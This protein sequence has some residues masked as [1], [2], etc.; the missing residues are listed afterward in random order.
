MLT[1]AGN[2]KQRGKSD[3]S[4]R[5]VALEQPERYKI[6][7]R[8]YTMSTNMSG[9]GVATIVV[10]A[11]LASAV[12]AQAAGR[13][14][15][16]PGVVERNK[17][18]GRSTFLP[19]P[20][21]ESALKGTR[22]A[23]PFHQSLN[24]K[25]K[26]NWAAKP[27]KRPVEFYKPS[28][29]VSG[30][31]EIPVPANWQME[32][33]GIPIYCNHP[34]SFKKDPP[35]VMGT[36]PADWPAYNHRNPV[37]SY[38]RE[39]AIP[40]AWK[41]RRVFIHF[42]GV[43]SAFYL[44]VNGKK[45]GYS[46]GSRTP[47]EFDITPYMKS[48]KNVLAAEVY[49]YSD[50]TYLECQDFWR[51]S[52]IFRDVYLWS[53]AELHVRDFHADATLD[54]DYRNGVLSLNLDVH[55]FSAD[56]K[57]CSMK[58]E[59]LDAKGGSVASMSVGPLEAKP[60]AN[61]K[62]T[63]PR[64]TI[65]EPAQWSAEHPNLYKVLITLADGAGKTVEVVGCRVGFRKVEIKDGQ[66]LVNGRAIY[67]KGVNR[68]EHDPVTGHYITRESMIRDIK[69]MKQHNINAVRTCH[70]PDDPKWYD[71]CDEFGIYLIDEANIE[72][73][74]MG[75]GP[76]SLGKKPAWKK[77][78]LDRTIR[79]VERDK[80]H[81]SI[82][83]WSL[84]N[85]AG[86]GINFEATSAWIHK[87][88]PSR[89]VHYERAGKRPHTDIVC[90]MYAGIKSIEAYGSQPQ[91]RPLILCE[92]A[93]A[94][95]NSVGNLQDYWT[96]IEK[97]KHLQ[98]GFI[99]D[100]V[101]QGLL[102]TSSPS[103]AVTD[104]S[105]MGHAVKI[106]GTLEESSGAK[107]LRGHAVL[108]GAPSLNITGK[109]LTLEAWVKPEK[110][111]THSPIVGKG[112]TQYGLKVD[113]S[114]EKLEFNIYSKS[115]G[116]ITLN[117]PLPSDWLG[118]WRHV[119]GVY[120]GKA[121]KL[122]IDGKLV[123][124][125]KSSATI[126]S[127]GHPVNIGRNGQ[128]PSRTFRGLIRRVRIY[129]KA[130]P[131]GEL[132][133]P[134]AAPPESAVL[135]V[136]FGNARK[137]T[138]KAKTFWAYG[139][140]YGDKP[141]DGNFCCNG[142]VQPDRRP[143]PSLL[144]VKKVYQNIKVTPVDLLKGSL[145]VRNK[146]IFRNLDFVAASWE[147]ACNGKVIDRGEL[148]KL[149]IPAG[150]TAEITIPL[151]KLQL[152]AG[153]EYHLKVVFAL[154][155]DMS[156]AARG[157]VVAWDQFKMPYKPAPMAEVDPEQ[158]PTVKL[159]ESPESVTVKGKRF[160]VSVG[161]K[162]GAITSFKTGKIELVSLPM[163]PDFWRVPIDNDRGNKMPDRQGV[164][165]NAGPTR[166]ITSVKAET[167][168]PRCV[169]VTA[170]AKIAAGSS[171]WRNVYT[172]TGDGKVRVLCEIKPSGKAPNLPRIGMRLAIPGSMEKMTWFGRGP[173]ETYMDRK[174]GA[175]VGVYSGKVA[176]LVHPYVRPQENANRTDVRWVTFVNAQGVGLRVG[177][178]A[179]VLSITA[180]P[181]SPADLESARHTHELPRRDTITVNIDHKQ[182]GVGGDN[183]W[184]ARPHRE[185]L[186][187]CRD[188]TY[189]FLLQALGGK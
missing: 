145:S 49:R 76:A 33:Y 39:F 177:G 2:E 165:K 64:I 95:G 14:W 28:F 75:Y 158:M 125:R 164:W 17:E 43:S 101:D 154:A 189:S 121:L 157:H 130:L 3:T 38:R 26:F 156:W 40:E 93:H 86:D 48:G 73:H 128:Y 52:G 167:L 89:P 91:T 104:A 115:A 71:L 41:G 170:T 7:Q 152:I 161:R 56:A 172:I 124:T 163:V 53:A 55:N 30:W 36:P 162:N 72:S 103:L 42:D 35:R 146:Y 60:G 106:F 137:V 171:T 116:W 178:L 45:V 15:E 135:W 144:E 77:A 44:W 88:D 160:S 122:Y 133:R 99:W 142:L 112:D 57:K 65:K 22:Q 107:A 138:S 180:R 108:P 166:K 34:Y 114:G 102:K 16:N 51:L 117:T 4:G 80:N 168:G 84:G 54:G 176:D 18:P 58:A 151:K 150:R 66:L 134:E 81:P 59:I 173:H 113:V 179:E 50:G 187:P 186:L 67:C 94:M 13:D 129:N 96:V 62:I 32:G 29:D 83:I 1:P 19:Y 9:V 11:G 82:I 140:D 149:K 68:H 182:M 87:R 92:Y 123:A 139:G 23:S 61:L 181:Y 127:C 74:G 175:A 143:N 37:G 119:A 131:I 118:K 25:W 85:E 6:R 155:D 98:G 188:Y 183:S 174:T 20:N 31:K 153:A 141:N 120:N 147:M 24:G 109:A 169:R 110:A 105:R 100:W 90:P 97:H 27:S 148:G 184:G 47:A 12:F 8:S 111:S 46:Q 5:W 159:T 132:N 70:Y 79:M 69:L 63:S 185:Y 78:H 126:A 21:V 136:D 10:L